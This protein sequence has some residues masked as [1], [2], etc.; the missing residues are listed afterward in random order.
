MYFIKFVS[1]VFELK[2]Y[3][4]YLKTGFNK[5]KKGPNFVYIRVV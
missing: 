3:I 5:F 1:L 2:Q 4:A